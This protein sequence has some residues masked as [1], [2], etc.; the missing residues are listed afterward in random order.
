MKNK[1]VYY[2]FCCTV[3]FGFSGCGH[4]NSQ[5]L[6]PKTIQ[7]NSTKTKVYSFPKIDETTGQEITL[8]EVKDI[9]SNSLKYPLVYNIESMRGIIEDKVDVNLSDEKAILD[10]QKN[11]KYMCKGRIQSEMK[12]NISQTSSTYKITLSTPDKIFINDEA[13]TEN[14]KGQMICMPQFDENKTVDILNALPI[15]IVKRKNYQF[16]GEIN[17]EYGK[18]AIYSNFKRI[19]GI[20]NSNT[21][22]SVNAH[23][24]KFTPEQRLSTFSLKDDDSVY[25]LYVEITPYRNGSKI[26]YS[27]IL[28]YV[29]SSEAP[30]TLPIS[31]QKKIHDMIKSIID[32]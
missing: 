25:P 17:S 4:D 2:I 9:F 13:F 18:D 21:F 5:I 8:N 30:S 6:L 27:T 26:N 19:L 32:N 28:P 31:K 3:I 24:L 14:I 22:S 15:K 10:I 16:K 11:A 12:Y 1:I 7:N 20:Y 23:Y 29:I